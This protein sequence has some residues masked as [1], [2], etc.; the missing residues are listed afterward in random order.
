[1]TITANGKTNTAYGELMPVEE[2]TE[3]IIM[4][5]GNLNPG[6]DDPNKPPTVT[7]APVPNAT[8]G[9]PVTITAAVTD[10]GLPKP[11]PVVT[12]TQSQSQT[13]PD[14]TRIQ[15]Q[16]TSNATSRPRGLTVSWMQVRGPAK[17]SF[18]PTGATAVADGKAAITAQFPQRGS[19]TLRAIAN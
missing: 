2:I 13:Q 15:A 19:Y 16:V 1:W 7:I 8:V 14:A 9:M 11:R 3:R 6:I 12:R 17:V 4:T 18:E 5:R 10:D